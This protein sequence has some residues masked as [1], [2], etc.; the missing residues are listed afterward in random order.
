MCRNLAKDLDSNAVILTPSVVPFPVI[1]DF[2][3]ASF[4]FMLVIFLFL[5][6]LFK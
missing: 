1:E 5:K 4:L 3:D 2:Y 6:E